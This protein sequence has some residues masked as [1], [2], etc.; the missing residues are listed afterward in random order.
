MQVR[1]NF[2][3]RELNFAL[4]FWEFLS[5][6]KECLC[7]TGLWVTTYGPYNTIYSDGRHCRDRLGADYSR[8]ISI[9]V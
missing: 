5:A 7:L 4:D 1:I 3:Q 2:I 9:I 6:S 8:K